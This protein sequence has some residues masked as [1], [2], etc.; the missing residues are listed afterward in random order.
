MINKLKNKINSPRFK[1]GTASTVI[2]LTFLAMI[3]LIYVISIVLNNKYSLSI[4]MTSKKIF[5]ISQESKDYL[6][7]LNNNITIRV[8]L[9]EK[10]FLDHPYYPEQYNQVNHILKMCKKYGKSISL[11]YDDI[12]KNPKIADKYD[13]NISQYS[14]II[15]TNNKYRVLD[16]DNLFEISQGYGSMDLKSSKAEQAVISSIMAITSS[17][18][19]NIGFLSGHQE[20]SLPGLKKLLT[21]NFYQVSDINLLTSEISQDMSLIVVAAPEKDFSEDEIKKLDKYLNNNGKFGKNLLYFAGLSQDNLTNLDSFLNNWDFNIEKAI[22]YDESNMT[23]LGQYSSLV[24]YSDKDLFKTLIDKNAYT[25]FLN[26]RSVK[27]INQETEDKTHS[28]LLSFSGEAVGLKYQEDSIEEPNNPSFRGPFVALAKTS[29]FSKSDENSVSSVIVSSSIYSVDEV[30][31]YKMPVA[32]ADVYLKTIN[33]ITD[34]KDVGVNIISK[35]FS[36]EKINIKQ[37][38][39]DFL[40]LVFVV[41]VPSLVIG[42]GLSVWMSRRH[43]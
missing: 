9:P 6:N 2:T 4:D 10:D 8:L 22:V 14:V 35:E 39:V 26:S 30:L 23:Q 27:F 1:H 12:I 21:D 16:I 29:K 3:I 15:E 17:E 11:I 24:E 25:I 41:F 37:N 42:T 31:L 19:I 13:S 5:E 20:V 34:K 7:N 43:K 33:N 18:Q 28:D 38:T 40:R 32:N 36:G